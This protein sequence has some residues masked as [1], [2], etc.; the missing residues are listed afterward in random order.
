MAL[1]SLL[2]SAS[3]ARPADIFAVPAVAITAKTAIQRLRKVWAVRGDG[4][5][6]T[7]GLLIGIT[8][9]PMLELRRPN[10]APQPARSLPTTSVRDL[11]MRSPPKKFPN[12]N[13]LYRTPH[14]TVT[15]KSPVLAPL[16]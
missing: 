11:Y 14:G 4:E 9:R 13:P 15:G 12:L 8:M 10:R 5:A 16:D 1:S 2:A 3:S 6:K 7:V